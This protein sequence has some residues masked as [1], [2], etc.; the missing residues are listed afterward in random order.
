MRE[1]VSQGV[2]RILKRR[3]VKMNIGFA[4]GAVCLSL[5]VA[6]LWFSGVIYRDVTRVNREIL[7]V[8]GQQAVLTQSYAQ[9]QRYNEAKLTLARERLAIADQL[10]QED[11]SAINLY[12]KELEATRILLGQTETML[13]RSND[14]NVELKNQLEALQGVGPGPD[15]PAWVSAQRGAANTSD[16]KTSIAEYRAQLRFIKEQISRLKKEGR[17]ARGVFLAQVDNQKLLLGNQGF[18]TK[19]GQSVQ[20]D[21][22]KYQRLTIDNDLESVVTPP[23]RG[24]AIDVTFVE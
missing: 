12:A 19:D 17:A 2:V 21:E 10:I 7:E 22:E 1:R 11:K 18:F 5:L 8:S 13:T 9:I 15:K 16:I 6:V 3:R 24:I 20:V 4:L 23:G 14:R